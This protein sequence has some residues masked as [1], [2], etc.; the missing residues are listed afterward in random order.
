MKPVSGGGEKRESG[1]KR[2]REREKKARDCA[3]EIEG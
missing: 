1:I 3:R 2:E